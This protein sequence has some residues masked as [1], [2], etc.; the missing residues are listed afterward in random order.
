[1]QSK[2]DCLACPWTGECSFL[3]NVVVEF[4]DEP[5]PRYH[6]HQTHVQKS[7][8]YDDELKLDK[9]QIVLNERE[10]Y[11]RP[12]GLETLTVLV[13]R[14]RVVPLGGEGFIA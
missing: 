2:L 3:N 10:A 5:H 13:L 11:L 1:M 8:Q 12:Q 6:L 7:V 14:G 4:R 9:M